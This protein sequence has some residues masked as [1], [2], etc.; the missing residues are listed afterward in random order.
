VACPMPSGS[1]FGR[2]LRAYE[3]GH[4]LGYN[5]VTL[6]ESVMNASA[7]IEPNPFTANLRG[8]AERVW[9]GDR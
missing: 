1:I 3:L 8:I 5:H 2:S 9:H 6:R 4:S 7:R